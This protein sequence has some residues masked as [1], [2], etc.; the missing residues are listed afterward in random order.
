MLELEFVNR[1]LMLFGGKTSQINGSM[2][3]RTIE[4]PFGGARARD[5]RVYTVSK[6]ASTLKRYSSKL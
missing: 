5:A 3:R 4:K 2:D 6:N 1:S